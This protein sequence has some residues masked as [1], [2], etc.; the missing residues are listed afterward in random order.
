MFRVISEDGMTVKG[1]DLN[2]EFVVIVAKE[3]AEWDKPTGN[4]ELLINME[5]MA[6]HRGIDVMR[7]VM[8]KLLKLQYDHVF[9]E[10]T[11]T[12]VDMS[13]L[14]TDTCVEL[15]DEMFQVV[16]EQWKE[17]TEANDFQDF[18]GETLAHQGEVD[19]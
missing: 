7:R 1:L 18:V 14:V 6:V 10:C 9:Y 5:T 13:K 17:Q 12:S 8:E 19:K 15:D 4:F 16:E 3:M 2:G 11:A